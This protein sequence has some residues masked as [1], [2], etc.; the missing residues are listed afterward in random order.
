MVR[1]NFKGL[2]K[3]KRISQTSLAIR[4][5][6]SQSWLNEIENNTYKRSPSFEIIERIADILGVK[7]FDIVEVI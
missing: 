6:I 2:R 4:V 7:L 1:F 3:L 5:G